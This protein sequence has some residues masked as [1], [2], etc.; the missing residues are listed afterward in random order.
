MNYHKIVFAYEY[1]KDL[2]ATQAAIRAGY[3]KKTAYSQGQRLLKNVEVKKLIRQLKK[4]REKRTKITQDKVLQ[5]LAIIGF[6]DI[7][8]YIKIEEGG[9][10]IAREFKDMPGS[11]RRAIKG[12]KE[13]RTIKE[14]ADGKQVTVYD[15]IRFDL[16]D[17]LKALE[18]IGQHLGMFKEDSNVPSNVIVN[19]ISAVPRPKKKR[20]KK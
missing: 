19:V 2:N 4:Q 11:S 18:K 12:V 1:I 6:S 17:K 14:D 10:I 7:K 3:S 16:W 13:D 15:K 9:G 20:K 8:N 5:E